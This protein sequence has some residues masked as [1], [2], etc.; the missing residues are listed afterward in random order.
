MVVGWVVRAM[1][2]AERETQFRVSER[3]ALPVVVALAASVVVVVW[4]LVLVV[5]EVVRFPVAEEEA[6]TVA[7]R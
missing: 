7:R 1:A 3:R 4:Q 5:A 6:V 2:E